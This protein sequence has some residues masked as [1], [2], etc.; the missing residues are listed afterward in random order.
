[1]DRALEPSGEARSLS[2]VIR[3]LAEGLGIEGF[4]PWDHDEGHID[5]VLDHPSTGHATV[6]SLREAGGLKAL[7]VSHVAHI[8][9]E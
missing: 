1:M 8:G 4:Y 2:Q 7:E 9:T 3:A 5:A 6:A